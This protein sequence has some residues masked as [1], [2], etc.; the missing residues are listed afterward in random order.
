MKEHTME[1]T[2]SP[3]R[4]IQNGKKTIE[5]R[6][7]DEK[8]RKI[9]VGDRIRFINSEDPLET[10]TAEVINLFVFDSFKTLYNELPLTECGYNVQNIDSASPKDMDVY[11][12][13]ERQEKYGVVGIKIMLL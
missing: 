8:R 7:Y 4:M 3:F 10:L 2:P 12:T 11:Y 1:L 5:L 13:K 6:L 9:K